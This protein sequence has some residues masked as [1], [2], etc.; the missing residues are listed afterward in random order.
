MDEKAPAVQPRQLWRASDTPTDSPF[1]SFRDTHRNQERNP[2]GRL[3]EDLL[4]QRINGELYIHKNTGKGKD[5][6][7]SVFQSYEA[8][9]AAY[10]KKRPPPPSSAVYYFCYDVDVLRQSPLLFIRWDSE[11]GEPDS[12]H[13]LIQV[14]EH[15][16]YD[17]LVPLLARIPCKPRPDARVAGPDDGDGDGKE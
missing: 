14:R 1:A 7:I 12:E 9:R 16:R 6:G 15:I 13:G 8:C 3:I 17:E 4:S 2:K 11:H 5:K 10:S